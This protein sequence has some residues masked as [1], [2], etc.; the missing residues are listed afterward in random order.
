MTD[1][2]S[3][4]ALPAPRA[5]RRGWRVLAAR[6]ARW[7][8][9]ERA[10]PALVIWFATLHAVLWTV[11]LTALKAAQDV[12]M[13]VAEA[14]AWGQKFLL[15][16]GKH[17]PLS[18]W[19]A[20]LW[21][22]V[23]PVAD[24]ASYALA[25]ATV[26]VGMVVCWY[27]AR[28]VVDHRRAFI[29]VL[30]LGI[31]PIFH[32]KGFKYNTDLL[33]LVTLPLI[34]L[35]FLNAFERRSAWSG[36]WLGLAAV[37]GVMTKYWAVTVIGAAGVAA[38]AHP[39]RIRFLRSPAPW[40]GIVVMVVG[41]LPHLWWLVQ[42][43]FLPFTYAG[44]V[45][46]LPGRG[47]SVQLALL[48]VGHNIALLAPVLFAAWIALFWQPLNQ[49]WWRSLVRTRQVGT[50]V[51][52]SQ[53][54]NVWIIQ[55]IIG[56]VPPIAAVAFA[57]Y[58]KTDWGIP[59]F[60][61]VPLAVIATPRLRVQRIAIARLAVIW[62][63]MTLIAL[64]AAPV[65]AQNTVKQTV[66]IGSTSIPTAQFAQQLTQMWH[67]RY[68]SRWAVV[69]ATTEAGQPMTFY[70]PDHPLVLTP[71]EV[72]TSGLTAMDEA[73]RFG[74]IGIC[75]QGDYRLQACETWMAKNAANA[76]QLNISAR[77]FFR[78]KSGPLVHWKVYLVPPAAL[79]Q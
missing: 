50:T 47:Q 7:A 77:R 12:H 54:R 73:K 39:D 20:G 25:M 58:I 23:F 37:A 32:F 56:L 61:L 5:R 29:T 34:V 75:D 72:W 10:A 36:V 74:F 51:N 14:Y 27:I 6:L 4:T 43:D 8:T 26:S 38:L 53:A 62:L 9:D 17:P 59:L 18:G 70:S 68:R 24:W 42:V 3:I 66:G 45:Y 41:L 76:E 65:I 2:Q 35:A 40:V 15:G 79:A 69:A 67:Q 11:T 33:Q 57:I 63:A 22:M 13:D 31:Y 64:A 44:D 78:G 48:Y 30:M 55:A 16:Y 19:V 28:R 60:F 21:F 52:L 1:V 71:N 46:E 49:P